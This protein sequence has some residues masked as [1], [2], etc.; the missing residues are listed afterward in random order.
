[1]YVFNKKLLLKLRTI[2]FYLAHK[3]IIKQKSH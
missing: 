3:L 2:L 1:M